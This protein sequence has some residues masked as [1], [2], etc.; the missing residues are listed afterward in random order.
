MN[1]QKTNQNLSFSGM[2]VKIC[3]EEASWR[4]VGALKGI[5][6]IKKFTSPVSKTAEPGDVYVFALKNQKKAKEALDKAKLPFEYMISRTNL[7][8]KMVGNFLLNHPSR[9]TANE[10][11]LALRKGKAPIPEFI[12]KQY[13]N[14]R[15][16][17]Y[18]IQ[19]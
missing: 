1:I 10:F 5:N 12:G 2:T 9:T 8:A 11:G 18:V 7:I 15:T 6:P 17:K 3:G 19:K 4:A 16:N 13:F 14:G